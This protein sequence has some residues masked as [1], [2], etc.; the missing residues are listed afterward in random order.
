MTLPVGRSSED[1]GTGAPRRARRRRLAFVA[2]L[3][4]LVAAALLAFGSAVLFVHPQLDKLRRADAIVSLAGSPL[5]LQRALALARAGFSHRI[6]LSVVPRQGEPC[7]RSTAS[8][9]VL[10]FTPRPATTRGEARGAA[11]LAARHGWRSL[12]VVA[13]VAQVSRARLLFERCTPAQLTMVGV[14]S[15]S[16]DLLEVLAYEWAATAKALILR[17]C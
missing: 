2:G 3:C 7:I 11:A 6:L 16:G 1:S 9:E 10:C 5:R 15:T 4:A 17:G 13:D 8:I 14:P 12:I